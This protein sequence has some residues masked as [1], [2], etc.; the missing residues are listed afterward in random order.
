MTPIWQLLTDGSSRLVGA[1]ARL[2][3]ITPE[4]K[5]IEYA[6]KFQFKATNNV[7]LFMG[8]IRRVANRVMP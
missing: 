6:L 7:E 5:V 4:R 2:V 3:L 1:G 8:G